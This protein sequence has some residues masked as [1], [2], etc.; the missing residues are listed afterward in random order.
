MKYDPSMNFRGEFEL[1]ILLS[2]NRP[3]VDGI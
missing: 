1:L 3:P 2:H